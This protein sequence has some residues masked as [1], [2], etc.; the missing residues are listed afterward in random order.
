[1]GKSL[2]V[3]RG[4]LRRA[5]RG[6][7][8]APAARSRPWDATRAFLFY[9]CAPAQRARRRWFIFRAPHAREVGETLDVRL[10]R[11][12]TCR[13]GPKRLFRLARF[14]R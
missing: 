14:S 8:P 10:Q 1:M 9:S 12:E 11:S 4:L 13:E 6:E 3:V 2:I 5:W 7:E